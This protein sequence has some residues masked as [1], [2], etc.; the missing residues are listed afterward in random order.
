MEW[1]R[2]NDFWEMTYPFMFPENSVEKAEKRSL[3]LRDIIGSEGCSLL[4]LCCGP[5]RYAVPLTRMGYRVTGVD[6][7]PFLLNVAKN[8]GRTEDLKVEWVLD[9]MK[10]FVRP[11]SFHAAVNMFTSFGYFESHSDN[12]R[13]LSNVKRSLNEDGV[14]ILETMGKEIL[15]SI[16]L[17][18]TC[19]ELDDGTLLIQRHSIDDGWKRI[20][21]D[22]IILREDEVKGRWHFFH[23]VYSA[24][25]LEKMLHDSGF[26]SVEIYGDLKGS[27]YD[28]GAA[29]LVAVAKKRKGR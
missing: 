11:G 28:S 20:R 29:R 7:T 24:A 9:D 21:N 5:G 3:L 15:A 27:P 19:Q 4:D 1:Y 8:R 22:W 18:T 13:V 6:R 12:M 10:T 25:E 23:W 16:F 17:D 2:D 14:F 26:A